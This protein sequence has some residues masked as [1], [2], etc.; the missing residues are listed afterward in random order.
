[1]ASAIATP[2]TSSPKAVTTNRNSQKANILLW[3]LQALLAALFLFAGGMKLIT[4]LAALEQQ[5]H[6][7]ALFL[8][9]IGVCEFLGALGLI[10][11]GLF[12]IRTGLTPLAACGLVVIMIGATVMTLSSTPAAM[13]TIPFV[14]GL[15][16][17]VVAYSRWRVIPHGTPVQVN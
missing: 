1:M 13:G 11:P 14:V 7:S 5:A 12:R 16:S 15:L 6:M 4:P 17:T 3:T 2:Y 9:F 8:R 10:L